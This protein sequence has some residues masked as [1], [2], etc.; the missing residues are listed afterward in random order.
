MILI[1]ATRNAMVN[2]RVFRDVVALAAVPAG[3][4]PASSGKT[5]RQD[6]AARPTE[7]K[8]ERLGYRDLYRGNKTLMNSGNGGD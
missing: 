8:A 6:A 7:A 1:Q 4:L 2:N 3:K 5:Q